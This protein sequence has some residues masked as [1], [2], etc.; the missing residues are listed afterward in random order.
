M[1]S[2]AERIENVFYR[3]NKTEWYRN[4]KFLNKFVERNNI[5][6]TAANIIMNDIVPA[7][8][9]LYGDMYHI[10][11]Y[12]DTSTSRTRNYF[13]IYGM[14]II[15][16]YPVLQIS[17]IKSHTTVH[18]HFQKVYLPV[19]D[20]C[21]TIR[22]SLEAR[23]INPS[24]QQFSKK[25]AHSH[26]STVD[27]TSN[28]YQ[29]FCLG[30]SST[31]F[32]V[33]SSAINNE[34]GKVPETWYMLFMNFITMAET[35]S[36]SGRPYLF[37]RDLTLGERGLSSMSSDGNNF[38]HHYNNYT[39]DKKPVNWSI[40]NGVYVVIDDEA[41][42]EHCLIFGHESTNYNWRHT[43]HKDSVGNYYTPSTETAEVHNITWEYTEFKD[44]IY[45]FGLSEGQTVANNKIYIHPKLKEYVKNK[46]ESTANEQAIWEASY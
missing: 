22:R 7:L 25:Y 30:G 40:E 18:N 41:L 20:D 34:G 24:I 36:L 21:I 8:E 38:I 13:H 31:E 39:T 4:P 6:Q 9:T 26:I 11:L 2:Y 12:M 46:L 42:E 37:I 17:N 44:H 43:L 32:N 45:P 16:R 28:S 27:Y 35:E 15:L 3:I 33:L 5:S 19:S 29:G 10:I 14:S 23:T 1:E